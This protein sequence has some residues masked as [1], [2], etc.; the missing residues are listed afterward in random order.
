MFIDLHEL[1]KEDGF[2]INLGLILSRGLY[3]LP[4]GFWESLVRNL[5]KFKNALCLSTLS[6]NFLNARSLSKF[7]FIRVVNRGSTLTTFKDTT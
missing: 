5:S 3:T 2:S 6:V 1:V 4:F 7:K